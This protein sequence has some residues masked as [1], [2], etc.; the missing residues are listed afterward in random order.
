MGGNSELKKEF[1]NAAE[2][3]KAS[4]KTFDND[5]LLSIYG[6]YKQATHGDCTTECPSFWQIKEKAKWE[7][8]NGNKG[9]SQDHAMKRY[10][11][12]VSNLL[13]S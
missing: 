3:I 12:K 5:T 11:K 2:S 4:G 10:I 13:Q 1:D 6:Y 7:A 8:W 9:M